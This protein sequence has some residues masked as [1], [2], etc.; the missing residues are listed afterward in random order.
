MGRILQ[1]WWRI[2]KY[3]LVSQE[4][5]QNT[6]CKISHRSLFYY[7]SYHFKPLAIMVLHYFPYFFLYHLYVS[8]QS[9]IHWNLLFC[10]MV[11]VCL[12]LEA[13][14][15]S[16]RIMAAKRTLLYEFWRSRVW[17]ICRML[18]RCIILFVLISMKWSLFLNM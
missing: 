14:I 7:I 11:C 2:T 16:S 4:S 5:F 10:G 18:L 1:I 15:P 13:H 9:P 6:K 8:V 12:V 3:G 17:L